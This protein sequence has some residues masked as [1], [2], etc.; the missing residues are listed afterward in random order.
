MN[1]VTYTS[2]MGD[3]QSIPLLEMWMSEYREIACN[4]LDAM[5]YTGITQDYYGQVRMCMFCGKQSRTLEAPIP[6]AEDC[7]IVVTE[8]A[9]VKLG[10]TTK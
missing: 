8:N 7:P 1:T 10:Q 3:V 5:K 2:Q 9:L 4:A 6:H